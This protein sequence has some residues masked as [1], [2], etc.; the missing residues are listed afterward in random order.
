MEILNF[1]KFLSRFLT[2]F[3]PILINPTEFFWPDQELN[4]VW[5]LG[6][7]STGPRTPMFDKINTNEKNLAI[8]W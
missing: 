4:A 8:L 7:Q 1:A 3:I 6:A 5:Q 2:F